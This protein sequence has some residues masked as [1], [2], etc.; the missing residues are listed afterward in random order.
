MFN[1]LRNLGPGVLVTAAFI[2]PG[3]VAACTVAGASFGYVLLWALLFA[4]LATIILQEMSARLGTITQ[5]G[6]GEV[7]LHSLQ[8]SPLKWPLFILV[9]LAL[10]AGNSAYEGGNLA[11]AALGLEAIFGSSPL[12]FNSAVV[13]LTLLGGTLLLRGSYRQIEHVLIALVLLMGIAFIVTFFVVGPSLADIAK[14][15]FSPQIPEGSLL[16]VIA[17]IGTT[18]VPYNLFL[19]ASAAKARWQGQ[20]DLTEARSDAVISIGLGGLI[21]ILI[22]STAAA[23]LFANQISVNSAADMAV[24]FEPLF[25]PFSKYLL[26]IG[27]F[28]AGLSST[29]TAPLATGYAV[30]EILQLKGGASG[31]GF[32][33]IAISVLVIGAA[34]ALTGIKPIKIILLA[35]FANGLLLPIVAGFLLYAM[36]R[37]QLLG[38]YANGWPANTLGIGVVLLTA[39][40]GA[41]MIAKG[42]GVM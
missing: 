18:V 40:L 11:G 32:R 6:M 21:A 19:H 3:T 35:Q 15:L 41:R 16:A 1:K 34:L 7:L 14:G 36:N 17:L 9:L 29:I 38:E 23:S 22:V 33:V 30:A 31:K 10:Y 27:L 5:K 26:G 20:K 13:A 25:G 39:G 4:T 12:V 42:L 24:Q 8:H 28:A 37:K 2:G